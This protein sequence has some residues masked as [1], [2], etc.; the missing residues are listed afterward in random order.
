MRRLHLAE[1]RDSWS[2]WLGVCVGF[3]VI[4]FALA[5]SALA[6]AAGRWMVS[7]GAVQV[8]DSAALVWGPSI[9][10]GFCVLVGGIVIGSSTSLVV[11]SRRGSLARLALAGATPGQVVATLMT[12]LVTVSV[13][14]SLVGDLLAFVTLRPTLDFLTSERGASLPTATPLYVVWPVALANLFAMVLAVFSGFRQARRASRIPAVEALRQ[15]AGGPTERMTVGRW[16]GAG[17][18]L[19]IIVVTYA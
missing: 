1:L 4:N 12:Q 9:N 19:V 2:V 15:S 14:C 6:L 8:E 3:V 16:L 5:L 10:I 17:V 18:Y 11:D 7:S 13:V